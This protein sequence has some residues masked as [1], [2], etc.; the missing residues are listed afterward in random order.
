MNLLNINKR[1]SQNSNETKTLISTKKP[2][3]IDRYNGLIICNNYDTI[4][5]IQRYDFQSCNP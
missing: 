4:T 1:L 5:I 3:V 2:I